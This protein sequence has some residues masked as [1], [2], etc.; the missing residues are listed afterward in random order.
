MSMPNVVHPWSTSPA[1]FITPFPDVIVSSAEPEVTTDVAP[2]AQ[3]LFTAGYQ[4]A[5]IA[6]AEAS[7]DE[8]LHGIAAGW[9]M[10]VAADA[11][12]AEQIGRGGGRADSIA[13]DAKG[14]FATVRG[15]DP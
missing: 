12:L 4:S 1:S 2:I 9:R 15:A 7:P 14:R 3:A 8:I 13:A 5:A 10:I 11:A 6:L